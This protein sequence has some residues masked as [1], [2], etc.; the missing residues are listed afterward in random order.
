MLA[1]DRCSGGRRL[2]DTS[3]PSCVLADQLHR[4]TAHHM[5]VSEL[6]HVDQWIASVVSTRSEATAGA[7]AKSG[8]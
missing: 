7:A 8:Y 3:A 6:D 2:P 4:A 5:A 1:S